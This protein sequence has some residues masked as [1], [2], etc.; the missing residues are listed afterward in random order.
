M[1]TRR[2]KPRLR[3]PFLLFLL[4]FL[5]SSFGEF[6]SRIA[7]KAEGERER[8]GE[9]KEQKKLVERLPSSIFSLFS[10]RVKKNPRFKLIVSVYVPWCGHCKVLEPELVS[11]LKTVREVDGTDETVVDVVKM[12]GDLRKYPIREE[13]EQESETEARKAFKK[14]YGVKG[15]P[16]LLLLEKKSDDESS[17]SG[18]SSRSEEEEEEEEEEEL[19][20]AKQYKGSRSQ[21][22]L[23]NYLR[24]ASA[25]DVA[26]FKDWREAREYGKLRATESN[27]MFFHLMV[28]GGSLEIKK[29][30][31][32]EAKKREN[33]QAWFGESDA[34]KTFE[35]ANAFLD[36]FHAKQF[37][38]KDIQSKDESYSVLLAV[39]PR[40]PGDEDDDSLVS[41]GENYKAFTT[42]VVLCRVA[43]EKEEEEEEKKKKKKSY[44]ANDAD[45][46]ETSGYE[47]PCNVSAFVRTRIV[48]PLAKLDQSVFN[49][50]LDLDSPSV[51]LVESGGDAKIEAFAK[52]AYKLAL[53]HRKIS[54]VRV[55]GDELGPWLDKEMAFGPLES[56]FPLCLGY[57]KKTHRSWYD[58]KWETRGNTIEESLA[59][60]VDMNFVDIKRLP[61]FL[62]SMP[63][64]GK[65]KNIHHRATFRFSNSSSPVQ[66]L[67]TYWWLLVIALILFVLCFSFALQY[68]REG[69]FDTSSEDDSSAKSSG[70]DERAA[71]VEESDGDE[72][73]K[74]K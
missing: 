1:K 2:A 22:A 5:L 23:L 60:F 3:N 7:A 43:E 26:T 69:K 27:A 38:W 63:L 54:F 50:I 49:N 13:M 12:N 11:A 72:P 14:K 67:A 68:Q 44:R 21:S 53:K 73:K 37:P 15:Y 20:V 35:E 52:N 16:T 29:A 36:A 57:H 30:F 56:S 24:R 46:S 9:Q 71:K 48:A 42:E 19:F 18:R 70:E 4:L 41:D 34:P 65:L 45:M 74:T 31:D 8:E 40:V 59:V 47:N 33:L 66:R 10:E 64:L 28:N 32:S 17:R 51:F 62:P 39:H 55:D 58:R 6:F 61:N 25:S